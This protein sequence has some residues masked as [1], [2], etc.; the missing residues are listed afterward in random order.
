MKLNPVDNTADIFNHPVDI[1]REDN[2]EINKA[3][4]KVDAA[5]K[6]V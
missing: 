6:T 5:H 4:T 1:V 3:K 2:T